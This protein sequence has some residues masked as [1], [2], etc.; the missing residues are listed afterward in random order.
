MRKTILTGMV[1]ILMLFLLPSC[2]TGVSQEEY[3]RVSSDL[4]ADQT[5]TQSLQADLSKAQAQ[6][7]SLQ[8]DLTKAQAQIQ[9]LQSGKGG[10]E[11]KC[12]EA[13]AYT[14]YL[15]ILMNRVWKDA[16]LTP[17]FVFEDE[18]EEM[19]ELRSRADDMG[20]T[21]LTSYVKELGPGNEA[22]MKAAMTELWSYCLDRIEKALK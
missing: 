16:G 5:Q 10:T 7:Q 11:E 2:A 13:L 19:L 1:L 18:I 21:T 20:D 9:S 4:A 15:D 12:A 8:G 6:I 14:E 3:D 22:A 17:R